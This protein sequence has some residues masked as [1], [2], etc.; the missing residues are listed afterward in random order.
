MF[1]QH[2]LIDALDAQGFNPR[3]FGRRWRAQCPSHGSRGGTLLVDEQGFHCFAGCEGRVVLDALGLSFGEL[4]ERS[5]WTPKPRVVRPPQAVWKNPVEQAKAFGCDLRPSGD[6]V[7]VGS[8]PS[9][10]GWV[11][12]GPDGAV[13]VGGCPIQGVGQAVRDLRDALLIGGSVRVQKKLN[14]LG[15]VEKKSGVSQKTGKPYV[16]YTVHADD[17]A[18]NRITEELTSFEELPNGL[19]EYWVEKRESQYGVQYTVFTYPSKPNPERE[20]QAK[21]LRLIE[22]MHREIMS[23]KSP[24]PPVTPAAQAVAQPVVVESS[25]VPF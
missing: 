3:Q 1:N 9:C 18:G 14:V 16:I 15:V 25:E 4:R 17:E 8:C 2:I 21:M 11:S 24:V 6:G 13:C 12:A 5:E 10:G 23:G 20:A 22:E 7:F 19:G